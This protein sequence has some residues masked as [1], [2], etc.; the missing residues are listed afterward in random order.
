MI[1]VTDTPLHPSCSHPPIHPFSPTMQCVHHRAMNPNDAL[2]PLDPTIAEYIKPSEKILK[3]SAD[4]R[5]KLAQAFDLKVVC[6][7]VRPSLRLS[8]SVSIFLLVAAIVL[9]R[10]NP[11]DRASLAPCS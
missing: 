11:H 1:A 5:R 9:L 6:A 8:V 10:F 3:D 7:C 2:P 4:A